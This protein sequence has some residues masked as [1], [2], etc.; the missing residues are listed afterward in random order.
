MW[1]SRPSEK[2]S[3]IGSSPQVKTTNS[4]SFTTQ[5]ASFESNW[6]PTV[7]GVNPPQKLGFLQV[8]ENPKI[9]ASPLKDGSLEDYIS[10]FLLGVGTL[11]GVNHV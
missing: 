4:W 1:L 11:L 8:S 6:H 7:L 3:Q 9:K 5:F 2:Y 10:A